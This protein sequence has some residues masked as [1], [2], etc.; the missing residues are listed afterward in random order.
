MHAKHQALPACRRLPKLVAAF[1][2]IALLFPAI[3]ALSQ[4][5]PQQIYVGVNFIKVHP[6]KQEQYRQLVEK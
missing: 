3:R 1:V 5:P 6:G 2:M 4:T